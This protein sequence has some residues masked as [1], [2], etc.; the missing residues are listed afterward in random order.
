MTSALILP[1]FF[2]G[3]DDSPPD[4][5]RLRWETA[6]EWQHSGQ[7]WDLAEIRASTAG[8]T[9]GR[10]TELVG[11][12]AAAGE[13]LGLACTAALEAS[14]W[15]ARWDEE[16]AH[17][18]A[19]AMADLT[20]HYCLLVGHGLVNMTAR[21]M[22]LRGEL[23][24]DQAKKPYRIAVES[25]PFTEHGAW[26]AMNAENVRELRRDA[27]ASNTPELIELAAL[28]VRLE[29]NQTWREVVGRRN[30]EFHRMRPQTIDGGVP[31][32]NPWVQYSEATDEHE[33]GWHMEF[34]NPQNPYTPDV[35]QLVDESEVAL[36]ALVDIMVE[37][38]KGWHRA[39]VALNVAPAQAQEQAE[40]G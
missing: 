12:M 14:R 25:P 39:L 35:A 31:Q 13:E 11:R 15:R 10:M 5:Q 29:Q 38:G 23:A 8:V 2:A 22:H 40:E 17:M 37:W 27:A 28:L 34:G 9:R 24:Y 21:L 26:L 3:G 20:A 18:A 4:S 6:R 36:D 32:V 33:S 7:Q 1:T 16:R 19:R 30:T